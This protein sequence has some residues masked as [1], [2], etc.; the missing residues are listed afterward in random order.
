MERRAKRTLGTVTSEVALGK[1]PANW[2]IRQRQE[3]R[4]SR[5]VVLLRLHS[6]NIPHFEQSN[7]VF[8]MNPD[9]GA[10][11]EVEELH[12]FEPR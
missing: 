10:R 4:V 11:D 1:V 8:F 2:E 7:S 5:I 6:N 9:A 3:I 12:E